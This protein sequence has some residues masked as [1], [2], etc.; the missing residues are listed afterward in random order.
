MSDTS[1]FSPTARKQ[2]QYPKLTFDLKLMFPLSFRQLIIRFQP[3]SSPQPKPPCYCKAV[4]S[5]LS[6]DD[7]EGTDGTGGLQ[8]QG[9]QETVGGLVAIPRLKS[10][11]Q[12]TPR[13]VGGAVDLNRI[14]QNLLAQVDTPSFHQQ[15]ALNEQN[16]G[17]VQE[18][19]VLHL[20]AL[21]S[22]FISCFQ[23]L[24]TLYAQKEVSCLENKNWIFLKPLGKKVTNE[25]C[26]L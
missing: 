26:S 21:M 16:D 15:T 19:I 7:S 25:Q 17:E 24:K 5:E 11:T 18:N 3:K 22:H 6:G 8:L 9:C 14:T 1:L 10:F 4:I 2:T 20:R 23:N 12:S 13:F